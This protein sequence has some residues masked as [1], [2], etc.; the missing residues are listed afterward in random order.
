MER[1]LNMLPPDANPKL[2]GQPEHN[3]HQQPEQKLGV[4][5][6]LQEAVA[7]ARQLATER[8]HSSVLDADYL[9]A[10]LA[11]SSKFSDLEAAFKALDIP[12]KALRKRLVILNQASTAAAAAKPAPE[13]DL[14]NRARQWAK[15]DPH[16]V[17]STRVDFAD[18]M[19]ALTDSTEP[20]VAQALEPYGLT[21]QKIHAAVEAMHQGRS[22]RQMM[23]FGKETLE[24]IAMVLIFLVLIKEALGEV[25]LIPS[26]S[27]VPLLQIEDRVVIEKI[28]R[29]WRPYERGDVL[30]FYPPTTRL[31]NDPWGVFLRATGFSG[32][33]YQK[34]DNIDVAY[35]KR[36]IGKPGD[37]LNVKPNDGVYINDE[38][39]KE[40]YTAELAESCTL[41]RPVPLCG[42]VKIPQ[43]YYFMMGDNRNYSADSR[44]WGLVPQD[45]VIGRAV[46]RIWPLDRISDLK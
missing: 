14:L 42:P 1:S 44:F 8:K 33:I 6:M 18:V 2:A 9:E 21:S 10:L 45:R 7:L 39:L 27:M 17:H 25:R 34:E 19:K 5:P 31:P 4:N 13:C 16:E 26:E 41:V 30:V 23:L 43:G 3:N 22:T 35:I 40:P 36:L 15:A 12:P 29:W 20:N 24:T 37:T 28:T 11:C 46:A 32:L 38:K